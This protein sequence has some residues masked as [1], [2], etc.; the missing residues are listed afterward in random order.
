MTLP[1]LIYNYW[2]IIGGVLS[3]AGVMLYII[4]RKKRY[5][6][7]ILNAALLPVAF[8]VSIPLC[9]L[10]RFDEVYNAS[11]YFTGIL[12]LTAAIYLALRIILL[13]KKGRRAR[14]HL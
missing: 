4:C 8:T 12:L 14:Q 5:S 10:G 7:K 2:M 11:Y 6:K 9:L 13:L 1:R 3:I